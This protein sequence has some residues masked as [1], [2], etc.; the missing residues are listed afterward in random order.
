M[1]DDVIFSM[2]QKRLDK[3]DVQQGYLLDGFPRTVSQATRLQQLSPLSLVVNLT[4]PEDILVAKL[5]G[6]RECADCGAG[7]NVTH[8]DQGEYDMPPLLPKQ[9]GLCDQC[10]ATI[11]LV[12]R[13]DDAECVVRKRL[14]LYKQQT[15][16]LVAFYEK[17]GILLAFPVRKGLGDVEDLKHRIIARASVFGAAVLNKAHVDPSG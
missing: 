13:A 14:A 6:R 4:L 10:G 17:E 12:Q 3:P 7:Y 2:V 8:I 16:P 1:P 11:K 5:L 15:M 9:D